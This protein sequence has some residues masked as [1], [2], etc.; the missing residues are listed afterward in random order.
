MD[1]DVLLDSLLQ[2]Y[3]FITITLVTL[4]LIISSFVKSSF[5]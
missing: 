4:I 5:I 3:Y 1:L 2:K